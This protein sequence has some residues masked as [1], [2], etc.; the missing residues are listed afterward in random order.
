MDNI[1]SNLPAVR[2]RTFDENVTFR[3]K[4][5]VTILSPVDFAAVWI[6]RNSSD[7]FKGLSQPLS[8]VL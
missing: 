2:A 1:L 8:R 5:S 4:G 3:S 7:Y 6:D